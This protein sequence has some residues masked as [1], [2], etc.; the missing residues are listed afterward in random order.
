MQR[1]HKAASQRKRRKRR[2]SRSPGIDE[3]EEADS[4]SD[5]SEKENIF[6]D[7]DSGNDDV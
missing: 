6:V 5:L 2:A 1:A 4:C 3:E 7:D